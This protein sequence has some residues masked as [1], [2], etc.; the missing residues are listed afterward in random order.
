MSIWHD[1]RV[2]VL[3]RLFEH[4]PTMPHE[5]K[6]IIAE[7]VAREVED[8]STPGPDGSWPLDHVRP[9]PKQSDGI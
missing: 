9:V 7:D 4:A 1:I 6:V 8:M 5:M 3:A 2:D